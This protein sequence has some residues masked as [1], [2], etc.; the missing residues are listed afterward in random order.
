VWLIG[1]CVTLVT[2]LYGRPVCIIDGGKLKLTKVGWNDVNTKFY[3]N[4]PSSYKVIGKVE[5]MR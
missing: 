2:S 3:E 5:N 1:T 4:P